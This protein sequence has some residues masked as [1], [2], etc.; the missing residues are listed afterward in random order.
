MKTDREFYTVRGYQ[1]LDSDSKILSSSLE[2]YL[3]MIYRICLAEGYARINQLADK[4]NV[5]PSSSTKIVQKLCELGLVE[6]KK[7][8]IIQL[9]GAG[10][11][12]GRY[13]LKRH[14]IIQEFLGNLG[15]EENLLRDTELIEHDVSSDALFAIHSLNNFFKENPEVKS[16]YDAY[17]KTQYKNYEKD[18]FLLDAG[19]K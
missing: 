11:N 1:M 3:E 10:E 4:L 12:I 9:T 13:L 16:Q 6:Y 7:Y 5:R 18:D 15:I 19:H 8:G 17:R 14:E 2:D